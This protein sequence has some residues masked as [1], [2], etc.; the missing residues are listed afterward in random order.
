LL[1]SIA[2]ISLVVGGIGVMNIM[3]VSVTERV[4]EIGIR[5]ATG[6]RRMNIMLQ[7]N[8]EA[9][10]V[11]SIGGVL[12]VAGGACHGLDRQHARP[13]RRVLGRAGRRGFRQRV[14]DRPAVRLPARAQGVAD[15]PGRGTFNGVRHENQ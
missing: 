12:G 13:A 11:C 7:F 6:A 15:G 4:R 5:M 2:A 10:V 1:G 14:P 3:L 9:L 8:T